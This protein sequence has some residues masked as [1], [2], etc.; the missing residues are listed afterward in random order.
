MGKGKFRGRTANPIYLNR[1]H[2]ITNDGGSRIG[3]SAGYNAQIGV[4]THLDVHYAWGV[5][6][7]LK[8]KT[9]I[10][11]FCISFLLYSCSESS[12]TKFSAKFNLTNLVLRELAGSQ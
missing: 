1:S 11:I 10:Y 4:D 8:V 6:G 12:D 7:R 9:S 5:N 2:W 3:Q